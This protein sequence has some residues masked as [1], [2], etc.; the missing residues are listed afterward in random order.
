MAQRLETH[1]RNRLR[2]DLDR[3]KGDEWF[4]VYG[5]TKPKLVQGIYGEIKGIQP[6]ISDHS[7]QHIN[8]V[9]D[10]ACEL[11]SDNHKSHGL[12]GVELY[13]LGMFILFHDVGNLFGREGHQNKIS[14]VYDWARGADASVRHERTL[15]LSAASAHTGT[16][17]DGSRDTLNDLNPHDHLNG[18]RVRLQEL[19]AILRFADELAEG[20]QRTSDFMQ[21]HHLYPA[22]SQVFHEYASV[23]NVFIDRGNGR[24]CLTYEIEA[25]PRQDESDVARDQRLRDLLSFTYNRIVKLDQERRYACYY[26]KILAPFKSTSV[27]MNFCFRSHPLPI[28]LNPIQ[29]EDKVVPGDP[30]KTIESLD[31]AYQIDRLLSEMKPLAE[32]VGVL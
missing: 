18:R 8:N 6:G 28:T 3:A 12:S 26:S 23:T 27:K 15:V 21:A 25:A 19:A 32:R 4:S 5:A 11:I 30:A 24:I 2:A 9:L 16:A 14:E 31:P 7:E 22:K 13:C 20:P 29:L 17:A 10:N 1:M